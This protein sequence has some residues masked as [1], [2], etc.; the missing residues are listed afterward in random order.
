MKNIRHLI[1][2]F[3]LGMTISL[4]FP[5][6]A[7]WGHGHHHGHNGYGYGYGYGPSYYDRGWYPGWWGGPN[8]IIN[9]PAP[10]PV[11]VPQYVPQCDVVQI[12]NSDDDCWLE[13]ECR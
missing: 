4:S 9:V 12:C 2:Y 13:R 6:Q 3:L 5:C 11:Y 10:G 8:V 7:S 1:C